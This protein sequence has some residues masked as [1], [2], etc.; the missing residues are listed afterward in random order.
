MPRHI[1]ASYLRV[2]FRHTTFVFIEAAVGCSPVMSVL[3]GQQTLQKPEQEQGQAREMERDL[4]V[5]VL[6]GYVLVMETG[7]LHAE[8]S[9][10]IDVGD[11]NSTAPHAL[12]TATR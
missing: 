8:R 7:S 12:G 10:A 6:D 4:R 11:V 5:V 3:A 2:V 1:L 9:L